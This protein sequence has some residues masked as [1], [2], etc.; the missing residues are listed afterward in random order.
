VTRGLPPERRAPV[1]AGV[2]TFLSVVTAALAVHG[3]SAWILLNAL[4]NGLMPAAALLVLKK[5]RQM[6]IVQQSCPLEPGQ[7]RGCV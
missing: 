6:S 3:L 2:L 4:I 1:A 5:R 7:A